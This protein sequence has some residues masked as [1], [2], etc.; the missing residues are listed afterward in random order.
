MKKI[1]I[2]LF[3]SITSL[4]YAQM[5]DYDLQS[6]TIDVQ[7]NVDDCE[8]TLV[9]D[10]VYYPVKPSKINGSLITLELIQHQD[11]LLIINCNDYINLRADSW[12]V[13]D[14]RDLDISADVDWHFQDGI[15]LFN[16][17]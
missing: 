13:V 14:E 3:L 6:I 10:D 11:Y 8:L 1:L 5:K 17:K 4:T 7:Q 9:L 16:Y 12:D 15:L 2:L